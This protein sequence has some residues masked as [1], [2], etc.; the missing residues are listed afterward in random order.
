[1]VHR[2]NRGRSLTY[3]TLT[4][5]NL[6]YLIGQDW[7]FNDCQWAHFSLNLPLPPHFH[8]FVFSIQIKSNPFT[9]FLFPS[10]KLYSFRSLVWLHFGIP[11]SLVLVIRVWIDAMT[12]LSSCRYFFPINS[13]LFTVSN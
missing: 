11:V 1:M 9:L 6:I 8:Y 4:P 3:L 5:I 2:L 7:A 10:F 13:C 12:L